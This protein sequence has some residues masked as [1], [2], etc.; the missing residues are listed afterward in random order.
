LRD[1][2]DLLTSESGVGLVA[3]MVEQHL[4]IGLAADGGVSEVRKVLSGTGRGYLS[5]KANVYGK[6]ARGWR[7]SE[8]DRTVRHLHRADRLLK[9]G[10]KDR[11]VL[12]ELLLT[13]ESERR[14]DDR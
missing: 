1:L 6:Q 2:D 8:I 12:T 3:G 14:D 4:L 10:G 7:T 13:L 11:P 5:W 9:S